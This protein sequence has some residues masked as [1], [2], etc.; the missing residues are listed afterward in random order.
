MQINVGGNEPGNM[1][2]KAMGN[3]HKTSVVV[4]ESR[5][6][7]WPAFS[8][9]KPIGLEDGK[10]TVSYFI[11]WGDMQYGN[12]SS[13]RGPESSEAEMLIQKTIGGLI[14]GTKGLARPQQGLLFYMST[15]IAKTLAEGGFSREDVVRWIS[16]HAVDT[17]E[18]ANARGLGTG[19]AGTHFVIQGKP[20]WETGNW[21]EE[22][23]KP[24]FDKKTIV[25]WYP[26]EDAISI[27]VGM[28]VCMF[29]NGNPR[30][31]T[32]VDPWK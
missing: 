16:N 17:Y 8:S 18:D 12:N 1:E 20:I 30:W 6:S 7:P 9:T 31:S 2:A 28:N 4:Y 27:V 3:P 14:E 19:V 5:E 29:Q 25:K 21:P 32:Y 24:D 10:S 26:N 15:P 23:S 22:W 11:S 13:Y